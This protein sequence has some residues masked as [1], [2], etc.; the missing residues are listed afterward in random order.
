MELASL[1]K[2]FDLAQ[3]KGIRVLLELSHTHFDETPTT[4]ASTWLTAM[5]NAVKNHPAA[6]AIVADYSTQVQ[7]TLP[8]TNH[9]YAPMVVTKQLFDD[10][11]WPD[12]QRTYALSF[13]LRR[14]CE[15]GT[16]PPGC[17]D[18]APTDWA[19]QEMRY[20]MS[21]IGAGNGARVIAIEYGDY[22]DGAST[23][24]DAVSSITNVMRKYGADGGAYW[25]WVETDNT[26]EAS[27]PLAEA[28]VKR[29]A[30]LQFNPVKDVLASAYGGGAS[31]AAR[32]W[33]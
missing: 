10:L 7:T 4:N 29:G 15:P 8:G 16:A 33:R 13:Y 20:T 32:T 2:L 27:L 17:V 18:A 3:Q 22:P 1:V 31:A 19:D 24:S 6:E 30:T 23:P 11:A 12:A 9:L 5:I 28:V 21:T 25:I 14:K 26:Y